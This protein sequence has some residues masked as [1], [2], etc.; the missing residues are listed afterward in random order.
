MVPPYQNIVSYCP[1][2]A[3]AHSLR[4]YFS[5]AIAN[6][7]GQAD[8]APDMPHITTISELTDTLSG[9]SKGT[10]LRLLF[11][12]YEAWRSL[13]GDDTDF[14]RFKTWGETIMSDYNEVDL[15][16]V[17]ASE[18]FQN[19]SRH[20]EIRTD[21]LT[22]EQRDIISRYFG[23]THPENEVKRFWGAFQQGKRQKGRTRAFSESL[24]NAISTLCEV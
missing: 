19:L 2:S 4:Q 24:G 12:L 16:C 18:L 9:A 11:S 22:P 6:M 21:Y 15:Y 5:D 20:N 8:D 23:I 3:A 7:F 13:K 14:E 10:R 1:P 17:E